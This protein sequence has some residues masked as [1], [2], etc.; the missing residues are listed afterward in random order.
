MGDGRP[1]DHQS[2]KPRKGSLAS[3]TS[4]MFW[5][6][7]SNPFT[8]NQDQLGKFSDEQD[9][10]KTVEQ[11]GGVISISKILL[12]SVDKGITGD[13]ETQVATRKKV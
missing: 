1:S 9:D 7:Q 10:G 2:P 13:V 11:F 4:T 3:M 5:R 12:S 8:I 6:R